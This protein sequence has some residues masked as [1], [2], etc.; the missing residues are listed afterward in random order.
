MKR[1]LIILLVIIAGASLVFGWPG[2]RAEVVGGVTAGNVPEFTADGNLK[3]SGGT[4]GGGGSPQSPWTNN[5]SAGGFNLTGV[6]DINATGTYT[7]TDSDS[8]VTIGVDGISASKP[9]AEITDDFRIQLVRDPAGEQV[10]WVI[11]TDAS[12]TEQIE[13]GDKYGLVDIRGNLIAS[14][15]YDH[16]GNLIGGS[17]FETYYR[18][19]PKY[20]QP[21]PDNSSTKMTEWKQVITNFGDSV[22]CDGTNFTLE[23]KGTLYII[24]LA[25]AIMNF[26]PANTSVQAIEFA[27][28]KNNSIIDMIS[29]TTMDSKQADKWLVPVQTAHFEIVGENSTNLY[30]F[31]IKGNSS[32]MVWS[33]MVYTG[34]YQQDTVRCQ[35]IKIKGL[36]R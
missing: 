5:T 30:T 28:R 2:N 24:D 3:D 12:D 8:I 26:T 25:V 35:G 4:G 6:N 13:A 34:S 23:T 11:D 19:A 18:V 14:N 36:S 33:N 20:Y 1:T 27:V 22:S 10:G 29:S 17:S 9:N 16:A 32:G 15:V 31:W 21:Y 7:A